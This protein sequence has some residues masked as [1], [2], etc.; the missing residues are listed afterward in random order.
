MMDDILQLSVVE[1]LLEMSPDIVGVVVAGIVAK[2]FWSVTQFF[3]R[4]KSEFRQFNS[5]HD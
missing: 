4:V 2:V 3:K 5:F 1:D